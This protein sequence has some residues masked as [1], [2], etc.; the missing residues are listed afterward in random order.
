VLILVVRVGYGLIDWC[1]V[2]GDFGFLVGSI[3]EVVR[4][5]EL[6]VGLISAIEEGI[7]FWLS[8]VY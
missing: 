6:H 8:I 5:D 7:L 1:F 3:V 4:I 2:V